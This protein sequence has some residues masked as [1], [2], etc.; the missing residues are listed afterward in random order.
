LFNSNVKTILLYGAET[1][2]TTKS[3]LHNLQ[4]FINNCLR[5]I[6]NIR[7]P[8]KISNKELW[9]KTNQPPV[10]EELKGENGGGYGTH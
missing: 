4:V 3:L 5:R 6:L 10:E 8:E 2:K 7:W 1:W 9:Q